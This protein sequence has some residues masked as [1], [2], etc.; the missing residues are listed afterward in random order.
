M[1]RPPS[2]GGSG[3]RLS[4]KKITLT[5]I[6]AAPTNISHADASWLAP[7]PTPMLRA[8]AHIKAINKLL[9]GPAAATHSMSRFG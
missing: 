1:M 8:N 5:K 4:T 6:P 3:S 2:S 9:N 7:S